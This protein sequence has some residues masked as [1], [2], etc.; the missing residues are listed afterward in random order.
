MERHAVTIEDVREVQ[1]NFKAG[2]TQHEGKE[3]QEAI[4]SFKTAASVLADEEHLKEFQKKLKSGKFKLQQ[5]SIAYMGCAA[6]HLNNL[7]NELDD[8]QKEQV[9]VDK[10]LT[11]AFRGW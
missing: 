4:E 10:Q 1:D 8:D 9:P 6:V 5:E 11:E 3:F 7:I 2:V